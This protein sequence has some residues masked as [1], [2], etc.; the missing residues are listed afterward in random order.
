MRRRGERG[1]T[2]IELVLAL[3][4]VALMLTILF[5]TVRA[6]LRAWQRGE[7]RAEM[8]EHARSMSQL[9]E[10]ALGG[11]YPFQGKTDQNSP[12]QII[13]QGDEDK[14]SFVTTSPPIPRSIPVAFTAVTLGMGTGSAAGLAIREKVLPNF[15]PFEQ[16]NP[17]VV[18][19]TVLRIAFRYLRDPDSDTWEKTW[20]GADEK[21]L[22]RAIEVTMT[23]QVNGR[24]E[25]RPPLTV[26]I[27]VTAP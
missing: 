20:S 2:L 7:E 15:D 27:R 12:L 25:E 18:D 13:F 3:T 11:A 17:D 8:L 26:P 1:F 22:P 16:V 5:G 10:L 23:V 9:V 14:L 4:I 19:P 21:M 24:A 6:G